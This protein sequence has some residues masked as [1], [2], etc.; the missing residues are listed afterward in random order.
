MWPRRRLRLLAGPFLLLAVCAEGSD[1]LSPV[2][3]PTAPPRPQEPCQW[4]ASRGFQ[5]C[6]MLMVT[7]PPAVPVRAPAMH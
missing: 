4:I 7:A 2:L 1:A 3:R 5:S 6:A